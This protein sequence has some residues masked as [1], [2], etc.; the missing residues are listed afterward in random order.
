MATRERPADIGARHAKRLLGDAWREIREARVAAGLSQATV[1][2]AAG[3]SR[4]AFG[5]MERG[6]HARVPFEYVARA[7]RVVGLEASLRLY[8]AG[9]PVRDAS[10]L[11]L[12]ADLTA[13][14]GDGLSYR[15][16]IPL[17]IAGD[18]RAWDGL[19]SGP[20][21]MAFA[22]CEMRLGDVQ[23]LLRRLEAKLRDDP[24]SRILVLAVRDT[25]HNRAALA[26]HREVL[27]A[28]LPL[29]S[30]AILRALRAGRVPPASGLLV[31][32]RRRDPRARPPGG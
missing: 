16:E 8:P 21:A 27:R 32:G 6:E 11:R 4:A 24:R 25:R 30:P 3:L 15:A 23:A 10:Q 5:R 12:E 13:V 19:I 17:P 29:D 20:R 9:A 31:L 2:R 14:L 1:G 26:E 22:E 18:L 28:L 7:A